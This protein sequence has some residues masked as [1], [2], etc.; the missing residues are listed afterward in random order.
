[1]CRYKRLVDRHFMDM[2]DECL[3]AFVEVEGDVVAEILQKDGILILLNS[4]FLYDPTWCG[5]MR[6][7]L[8]AADNGLVGKAEEAELDITDLT[9]LY[10]AWAVE[11]GH[12]DIH[13]DTTVT[14]SAFDGYAAQMVSIPVYQD[15]EENVMRREK[16]QVRRALLAELALSLAKPGYA[17]V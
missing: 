12:V 3:F 9:V 16:E 4:R 2:S 14:M 6:D 8:E 1:M 10:L 15:I 13:T 5:I 17:R 11:Y 7:K